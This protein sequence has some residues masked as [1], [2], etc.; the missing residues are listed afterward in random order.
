MKKKKLLQQGIFILISLLFWVYLLGPNYINPLNHSWLYNGDLS[1]YQLGW[2]FFKND[3]WRF[4]L[5]ANPDYGIYLGGSVIFSDSIPFL[6]FIFKIFKGILP[7]TFQYF[8]FWILICIYLQIFISHKIVLYYTNN[9][10]YSLISSLFFLISTIFIHRSGIHLS[11]MGHWIILLYFLINL[12]DQTKFKEHKKKVLILFS[13]LIHFYFTMILIFI[14]FLESFMNQKKNFNYLLSYL[15]KNFIFLIILFFLMYII[16][17]FSLKIDDGLGG[18]YGYFNYNLNSFFNPKGFNNLSGFTWSNFLPILDTKNNNVE[19]FS[20][21]GLSGIIFFVIYI[22]NIKR[23]NINI[24]FEKK[25]NLLICVFFILIATSNNINF[26]NYNIINIELNKYFYLLLSSVRASGRMVWPVYYLIFLFGI[27]YIYLS[28]NKKN[29]NLIISFLLILQFADLF[30]GLSNYKFGSQFIQKKEQFV[31]SEIWNDLSKEFDEIR[32]INPENQSE[33]FSNLAKHLIEEKYKKTDV[34]YLARVNRSS[35]ENFRYDQF[36]KFNMRDLDIF[37]NRVFISKNIS[38]INNLKILYRNRINFYLV[39]NIWII[40]NKNIDALSPYIFPDNA[41]K[42]VKLEKEKNK[43]FYSSEDENNPFGFGWE[44][45]SNKKK[46]VSL[47][48]NSTMIFKL[49]NELCEKKFNLNFDLDKYFNNSNFL[50]N[51]RVIVNND[52]S[53]INQIEDISNFNL[54]IL[55]N[56]LNDNMVKIDFYYNNPISKY[57]K[58]MGLNRKKRAIVFNQIQIDYL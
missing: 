4:P 31:Q 3:I 14:Y 32:L 11:L 52:T 36:K 41:F 39:D 55:S 2:K 15:I 6:A 26:G 24:I 9:F 27:V 22:L 8:S 42:Y 51:M 40:T 56:C 17:Y 12:P 49:D 5:G 50:N 38:F 33:L 46:F 10:F 48:Y 53:K 7:E 58:K 18:G 21:L 28:F 1:I 20:Y 37:E 30:P 16:G 19:G 13:C 43:Y 54:Q 29:A 25:T 35:L 23:N 45:D 44:F 47:G 57:D 34:A